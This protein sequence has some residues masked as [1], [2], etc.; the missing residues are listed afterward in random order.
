MGIASIVLGFLIVL[1][2]LGDKN[3]IE[4]KYQLRRKIGLQIVAVIL[5]VTT[6]VVGSGII[7]G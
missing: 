2:D 3:R 5:I 7:N 1:F 4:N 6:L